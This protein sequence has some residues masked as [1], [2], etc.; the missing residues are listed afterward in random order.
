[1]WRAASNLPPKAMLPLPGRSGFVTSLQQAS[2][3]LHSSAGQGGLPISSERGKSGREC[4]SNLLLPAGLGCQAGVHPRVQGRTELVQAAA[5]LVG[6]AVKAPGATWAWIWPDV[7]GYTAELWVPL[8]LAPLGLG[9]GCAISHGFGRIRRRMGVDGL[10][11]R[12]GRSRRMW[13]NESG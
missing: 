12:A 1:M 10:A 5:F 3:R 13:M 11:G 4:R 8:G 6:W 9:W 2:P 7:G